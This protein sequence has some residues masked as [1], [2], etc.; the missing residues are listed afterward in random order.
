MVPTIKYYQ[1][2]FRLFQY[3]KVL[4]HMDAGKHYLKE[5]C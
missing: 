5:L 3:Y 2:L 1:G 4:K